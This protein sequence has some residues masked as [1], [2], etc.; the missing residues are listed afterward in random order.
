MVSF[1]YGFFHFEGTKATAKG[2]PSG[3]LLK[4]RSVIRVCLPFSC[5]YKPVFLN[6][7]SQ[8]NK[9]RNLFVYSDKLHELALNSLACLVVIGLTAVSGEAG[10]F[11]V[12]VVDLGNWSD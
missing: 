5:Q 11:K 9:P 2:N 3:L 12:F 4:Q 7:K 8:K 1:S 10:L 6:A